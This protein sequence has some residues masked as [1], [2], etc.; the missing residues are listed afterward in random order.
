MSQASPNPTGARRFDVCIRGA[1][2]VGQT[3][4]L[5]LARE[6]LKV[7]LVAAPRPAASPVPDVRAYALNTAARSLLQ[8]VRGWPDEAAGDA[9]PAVTPVTR[10]EVHGDDGGDLHFSA[11]DQ[12]VDAL[13]WIVDVPALEKRLADAVGFQ[14]GIER[15]S[16]PV[17]AALTVVCEGR[18][19]S[20]RAELGL[21]YDVRPY[22]HKA[23]A[24]RL[25]TERP[26]GGVARQWFVRGEI[27]ALLPLDGASGNSVALVWSVPTQ[28]S[29]DW[30][31]APPE[32]LVQ[33]LQERCGQVL[34]AMQL[35]GPA[36]AWPLE[37]SRARRWIAQTAQG[38][39]ALAGDAAHA[40]HPLA[41]QG[42]NVGLA[43]AAALARVIHERE[44][45]REP[46]DLRL[47]RRYERARQAEVSAM[48][49]L[50]DGL[51]GLF[52]Q[53]DS[54]VQALRNWGMSG[55]DRL[56]PLKHWLARKAMG[57]AA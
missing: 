33:A 22:P 12:G 17:P 53:P 3:L 39:V 7:A 43:D 1:G 20:T 52:G 29:E 50:T 9:R 56:G 34:G 5:L 4:A 28:Q 21:D 25:T 16:A 32:A 27:L 14:G 24:A 48:G 2:V 44:F 8:S 23:I 35:G 10:M 15:V 57:Q 18:R 47:L 45:W 31:A 30:L 13:N 42:L 19:S 55:V 54:R 38:S 36:Q 37:L 46:G 26:H 6:R 11:Q 51:F 41:G 40:M 49:W